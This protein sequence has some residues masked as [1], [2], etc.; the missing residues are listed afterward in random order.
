MAKAN[1]A[2]SNQQRVIVVPSQAPTQPPT[3][4]KEYPVT[5]KLDEVVDIDGE[6]EEEIDSTELEEEEGDDIEDVG[7]IDGYPEFGV[8]SDEDDSSSWYD[9]SSPISAVPTPRSRKRSCDELDESAAED[10]GQLHSGRGGTPPKRARTQ[11]NPA[12]NFGQIGEA[13]MRLYK[14]RSSHVLEERGG[15]EGEV[16]SKG[17]KRAKVASPDTSVGD[18]NTSSESPPPTSDCSLPSST[19]TED[20]EL[21]VKR[22]SQADLER[23]YVLGDES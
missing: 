8:H 21:T 11:S 7:D 1:A 4:D 15:K 14:K 16:P 13:Q 23:L 3:A 22:I 18:G 10:A 20:M 2:N 19:S 12:P 17:C 9:P 5:V 6:G